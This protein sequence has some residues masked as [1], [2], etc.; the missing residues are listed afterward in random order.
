MYVVRGYSDERTFPKSASSANVLGLVSE[1]YKVGSE[2]AAGATYGGGGVDWWGGECE[3]KE[4][5]DTLGSPHQIK[6]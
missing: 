3:K 5:K 6:K 1:E 4:K 2:V